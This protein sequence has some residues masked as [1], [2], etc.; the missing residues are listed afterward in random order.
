MPPRPPLHLSY[1]L[2]CI[3]A[4]KV[5]LLCAYFKVMNVRTHAFSLISIIMSSIKHRH[6]DAY[7]F[8]IFSQLH[9]IDFVI[10]KHVYDTY[11]II[12]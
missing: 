9:I 5:F 2:S 11:D 6:M 1:I 10:D 4:D 7:T 8:I 3:M 12:P